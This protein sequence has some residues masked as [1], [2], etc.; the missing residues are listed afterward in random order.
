MAR[1]SDGEEALA[2]LQVHRPDLVF[3]DIEMPLL[4]GFQ[5]LERLGTPTFSII[6]TTAYSRYAV[7]AFRFSALDFLLKPID[8]AEFVEAVNRVK[9]VRWPD[10]SEKQLGLLQ[11]QQ[12]DGLEGLTMIALPSMEGLRTRRYGTYPIL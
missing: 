2:A 11:Q 5:V 9:R 4:N 7:R 12:K 8:P 10:R 1:C 3:M 6:F